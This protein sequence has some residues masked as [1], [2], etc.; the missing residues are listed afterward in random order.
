MGLGW[1]SHVI[2]LHHFAKCNGFRELCSNTQCL[3]C[4][5]GRVLEISFALS[6]R[7]RDRSDRVE[8]WISCHDIRSGV[9]YRDHRPWTSLVS[10][11]KEYN[12]NSDV[13][14]SGSSGPGPAGRDPHGQMDESAARRLEEVGRDKTNCNVRKV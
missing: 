12:D 6:C 14:K 9:S 7:D 4:I 2:A 10:D 8:A 3:V 11:R 13:V 1:A 5:S